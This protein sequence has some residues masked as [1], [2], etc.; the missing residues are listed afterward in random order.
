MEQIYVRLNSRPSLGW[1]DFPD[2]CSYCIRSISKPDLKS[3]RYSVN[4]A[5]IFANQKINLR[6]HQITHF[7]LY[8][9]L[10]KLDCF[11]FWPVLV[12]GSEPLQVI[13]PHLSLHLK[14]FQMVCDV[15]VSDGYIRLFKTDASCST[16]KASNIMNCT[17]CC[18]VEVPILVIW[19]KRGSQR[20]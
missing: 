6:D 17:I 8:H 18:N 14:S 15:C 13:I 3:I 2:Y 20:T 7:P 16:M 12:L 9:L 11:N 19:R 5:L 4:I 10:L 1:F